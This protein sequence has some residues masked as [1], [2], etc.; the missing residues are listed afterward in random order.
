[1]RLPS[2]TSRLHP[3]LLKRPSYW[4][5]RR[6]LARYPLEN[7]LPTDIGQYE[8]M[9]RVVSH[10]YECTGGYRQLYDEAGVHPRDLRSLADLGSFPYVTKE[11]I[12]DNLEEFS[13]KAEQRIYIT[14]GGS[15]GIPFGFYT[16]RAELVVEE[17]FIHDWWIRAGWCLGATTAVLRGAFVGSEAMPARFSAAE[18]TLSLSSYYI[19]PRRARDYLGLLGRHKVTDLQAYPSSLAMLLDALAGQDII[20]PVS[21]RRI[22][23]G[24]ENIYDWLIE[25]AR[26][27]FPSVRFVGW[28]G[29]AERAAFAWRL[30]DGGYRVH[31]LYGITELRGDRGQACRAGEEGEIVATALHAGVTPFVRYR[32][33]DRAIQAGDRPDH[34]DSIIGR[35]HE[36]LV[37]GRGR[38]ISM[39]AI[40]MHDNLFDPLLQFQFVQRT[41]GAVEFLV[42]PRSPL[43]SSAIA[44]IH[45]GLIVKLGDDIEVTV[46]EVTSIPRTPSG[47]LRF[48]DQRLAVARHEEVT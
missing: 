17:A 26:V 7:P 38:L 8:R 22:L 12:R 29:Q 4:L 36:V 25:K 47:K 1:M 39:T 23:L 30:E 20:A 2:L 9:H 28:Y 18:R 42:V 34:W 19:D 27:V 41:K 43:D 40:N 16:T 48:L 31:P 32:T 33:M 24:S 3:A 5:W 37:T 13:L 10:A 11:L 46:R 35:S 45:R 21:L 15:T 6:R 44:R 14:T